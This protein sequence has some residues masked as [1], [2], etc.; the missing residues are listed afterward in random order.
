MGMLRP[1]PALIATLVLLAG[2]ACSGGPQ[3]PITKLVEPVDVKTGW[4]DAGVENGMNKLVPSATLS[5]RNI[6]SEPVANVQLNAVI[7]RVGETEEWGGAFMKVVGT[8][9]IPPGGQTKPI[10]LRSNLGYTGTEPRA[11]MLKNRQF[12]DASV[13][14]FAKH[15]GN[16]WVKLGE[17]P[18]ARDLLTQ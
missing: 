2:S 11:Q 18:I 15:G 5:L 1:V 6:S 3:Q 13:Q 16:Q 8:E 14:V 17:W 10:I 12:V 7:R 9:G 4:F